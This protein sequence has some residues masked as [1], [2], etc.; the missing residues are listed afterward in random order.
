MTSEE[1]GNRLPTWFHRANW[2]GGALACF[3]IGAYP[4]WQWGG[5]WG[6]GLWAL[7]WVFMG[8]GAA[9]N[10]RLG[11]NSIHIPARFR[12]KEGSARNKASGA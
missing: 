12:K 1:Y 10:A 2:A 8:A 11:L 9:N 3:A 7:F 5:G 4:L 6:T